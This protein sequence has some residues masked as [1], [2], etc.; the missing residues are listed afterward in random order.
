MI[1]VWV[2]SLGRDLRNRYFFKP[3]FVILL[4][5]ALPGRQR[6]PV[7][8]VPNV[9]NAIHSNLC[10]YQGFMVPVLIF[11][12]LKQYYL[13]FSMQYGFVMNVKRLIQSHH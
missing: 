10:Q 3:G 2:L 5:M 12:P 13:L 8:G 7:G 1:R 6:T 11:F 4:S 9:E